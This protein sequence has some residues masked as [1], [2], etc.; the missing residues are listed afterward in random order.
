MRFEMFALRDGDSREHKLS[1]KIDLKEQV[2]KCEFNPKRNTS[3][4]LSV[5][6]FHSVIFPP[7]VIISFSELLIICCLIVSWIL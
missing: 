2:F 6:N 4:L 1:Y 3:L 5:F 7:V